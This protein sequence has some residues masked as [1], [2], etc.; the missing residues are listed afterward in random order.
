[1]SGS[2]VGQKG[3]R[4]SDCVNQSCKELN[5]RVRGEDRKKP[6]GL[7]TPNARADR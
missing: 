3:D 6:E 1:M 2:T 5:R 4:L 7:Q